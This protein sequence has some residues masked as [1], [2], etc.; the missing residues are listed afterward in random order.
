[1]ESSLIVFT[2]PTMLLAGSSEL[3]GNHTYIQ[4]VHCF[5]VVKKKD[6]KLKKNN[7][8]G[9]RVMIFI[10]SSHTVTFLAFQEVSPL[11]AASV[12]PYGACLHDGSEYTGNYVNTVPRETL[13]YFHRCRLRHIM[14]AKPDIVAI[15]TIPALEEALI[16]TELLGEFPDARAWVSLQCRDEKHTAFGDVFADAVCCLSACS[17]VIAVGLNC[18]APQI[19]EPLLRSAAGLSNGK[20]FVVYPNSGEVWSAEDGASGWCDGDQTQVKGDDWKKMVPV[21]LSCGARWIG[22][23]CRVRPRDIRTIRSSVT[24]WL[25][26]EQA[27]R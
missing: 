13:K 16:L 17:Q 22:G 6:K 14:A 23:C 11:V 21:W 4:K 9:V 20:P 12:G 10:G 15:E 19:V 27:E 24:E 2:V 25:E 1:M 8:A 18:C 26:Y 5:E 7:A 3:S